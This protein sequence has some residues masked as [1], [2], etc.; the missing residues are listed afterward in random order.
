M[1]FWIVLISLLL[2]VFVFLIARYCLIIVKQS[3][4]GIVERLGSFH[5]ITHAGINFIFPFT[6]K[7]INYIDMKEQVR[8]FPPQPVITK[9]NVTMMLDTVVYFKVTDPRKVQYEIDD[10]EKAIANLTAT[11]LRNVIGELELDQTLNSRDTVNHRLR[12]VLDEATDKWGI[13]ITRVELKDIN[14]PEDIQDTMESQMRAERERRA[15]ILGAEGA[16]EAAIKSAEGDREAAIIRAQ[17]ER[18][19]AILRAQGEAETIRIVEQ[20]RAEMIKTVF[21]AMH[22]G[23]PDERIIALRYLQTLEKVADGQA[24]KIYMPLEWGGFMANL[25]HFFQSNQNTIRDKEE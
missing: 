25:D 15:R 3:K 1:V 12:T 7:I 21:A 19:A 23:A 10:V 18:E 4:V 24:S 20:A 14:P 8:D 5:K 2:A 16:R 13:K 11:T 6:D 9:D 22:E 17:G